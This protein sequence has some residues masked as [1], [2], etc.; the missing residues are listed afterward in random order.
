MCK[1]KYNDSCAKLFIGVIDNNGNLSI[2]LS[3][4]MVKFKDKLAQWYGKYMSLRMHAGM[5]KHFISDKFAKYL[6]Q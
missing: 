4:N 5:L 6:I 1:C 3:R 2:S